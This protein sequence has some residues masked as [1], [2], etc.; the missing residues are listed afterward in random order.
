MPSAVTPA[1]GNSSTL[2]STIS[3]FFLI[4]TG[5]ISSSNLPAFW[6]ASVFCWEEAAKA[7]SSSRVMPQISQIF[8]AVVPM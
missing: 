3:F 6:A 8:S 5:T 2:N 4:I 7:S 1:L